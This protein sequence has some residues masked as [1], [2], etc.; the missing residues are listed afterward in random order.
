MVLTFYREITPVEVDI[1]NQA[2]VATGE[3]MVLS[4]DD[5]NTEVDLSNYFK[6]ANNDPLTYALA[7]GGSESKLGD[8]VIE[9]NILRWSSLHT[10]SS[11][12]KVTATD[13][14]GASVTADIQLKIHSLR[15][16]VLLY[17]GLGLLAAGGI[18]SLYWFVLKPKPVFRGRLKDTSWP[19][20]T[21]KIFP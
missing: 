7:E 6:D 5:S 9:G 19:L 8:A 1:T 15:E 16:K 3:S 17:T 4:K 2:P 20:Q 21:E 11:S 13:S 10:G 14:E 12:I 18:F